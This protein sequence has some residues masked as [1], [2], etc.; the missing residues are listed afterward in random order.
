MQLSAISATVQFAMLLK[1]RSSENGRHGMTD[2]S[3]TLSPEEQLNNID[4]DMCYKCFREMR[5]RTQ[6]VAA[7]EA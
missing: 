6:H 2:E 5:L 4:A 1:L 7:Q 3:K